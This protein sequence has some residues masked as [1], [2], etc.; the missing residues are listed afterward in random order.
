MDTLEA[1]SMF[2]FTEYDLEL[3]KQTK[4]MG[5]LRLTMDERRERHERLKGTLIADNDLLCLFGESPLYSFS[6]KQP[7]NEQCTIL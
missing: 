6:S 4:E 1:S 5:S 7:Q 2:H 3:L